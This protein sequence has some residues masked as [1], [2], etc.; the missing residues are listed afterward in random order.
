MTATMTS[1][2]DGSR[3]GLAIGDGSTLGAGVGNVEPESTDGA[4]VDG[5]IETALVGVAAGD[6]AELDGGVLRSMTATPWSG[7]RGPT[8]P[9]ARANEASTRLRAPKAR[10]RRAR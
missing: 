8:I 3:L 1:L 6:A 4:G 10:T 5:S 9:T 2:G 7:W